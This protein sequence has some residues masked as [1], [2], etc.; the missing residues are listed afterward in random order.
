M[1]KSLLLASKSSK[2]SQG[3]N[4]VQFQSL[5]GRIL[6]CAFHDAMHGMQSMGTFPSIT[7]TQNN[8]P[9]PT[10]VGG[11]NLNVPVL[12]S[13]PGAKGTIYLDFDGDTAT[14]WGG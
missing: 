8:T 5:E 3:Q 14:N 10:Q 7:S 13:L 9:A 4:S 1:R 2:R 11:G 12:N 6:F